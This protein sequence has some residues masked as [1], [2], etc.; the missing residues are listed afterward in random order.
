MTILYLTRHGET[1][2]NL[3]GRFQGWGDSPLTSLGI[4]QA[5]S[6]QKRLTS[7]PIDIIYSSD[8]KRAKHTAEL[9]RGARDIP[10]ITSKSLREKGFGSWEGLTYHEIT[11]NLQVDLEKYFRNPSLNLPAD[12]EK[13]QD[14]TS[15]V[16]KKLDSI[17]KSHPEQS[18]LVVTHGLVLKVL[19]A[20]FSGVDLENIHQIPLP[21][22]A[23]LT[24]V[25]I[26]EGKGK[27]VLTADTDHHQYK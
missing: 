1:Q 5:E 21:Q 23:S 16:I 17:A 22:Q 10:L 14:F 12:G 13:Y 11:A 4:K 24:V 2:W 19:L 15:R 26:K 7:T 18:V 8:L 3:E 20:H 25:T 6:L 9:V 27:L